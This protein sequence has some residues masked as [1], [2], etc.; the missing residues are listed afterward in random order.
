MN[1]DHHMLW[2][3]T[4][5]NPLHMVVFSSLEIVLDLPRTFICLFRFVT[6]RRTTRTDAVRRH[7]LHGLPLAV[8][9]IITTGALTEGLLLFLDFLPLFPVDGISA[10]DMLLGAGLDHASQSSEQSEYR[11]GGLLVDVVLH[12]LQQCGGIFIAM[13]GGCF[14]PL[15]AHFPI[16]RYSLSKAIDLAKL[17][18]GIGIAL[19]RCQFEHG[20]GFLNIS[21]QILLAHSI[22]RIYTTMNSGFVEELPDFGIWLHL[23]LTEAFYRFWVH[24][25]AIVNKVHTGRNWV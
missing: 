17:V 20:N 6:Y 13:A 3:H 12:L 19:L 15:H 18:F 16:L 4:S 23:R 2:K 11:R 5:A 21:F 10:A 1:F 22:Y 7:W 9:V 14:Q 24:I 8:V 25:R